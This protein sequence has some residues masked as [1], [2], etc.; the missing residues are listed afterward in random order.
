M[1]QRNG[2]LKQTSPPDKGKRDIASSYFKMR[3]YS[4]NTAEINFSSFS[5]RRAEHHRLAP[6]LQKYKKQIVFKGNNL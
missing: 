4:E 2:S 6:G 5:K 3:E 1:T